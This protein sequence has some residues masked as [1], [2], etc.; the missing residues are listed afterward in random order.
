MTKREGT[1]KF[2][3]EDLKYIYLD[4][5]ADTKGK[6]QTDSRSGNDNTEKAIS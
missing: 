4:L 3:S 6:E 1:K 5:E 2:F